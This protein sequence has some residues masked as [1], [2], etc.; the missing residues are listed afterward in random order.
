MAAGTRDAMIR[1]AA[2]LLRQEGIRGT[3]FGQVIEHSGAPRGS[4]NHH[5]PGGKAEMMDAALDSAAHEV[6]D[7]L[8]GLADLGLSSHDVVAGICDYFASGLQ[9][10]DFRAG[11]P[12]AAIAH[13]AH[14]HPELKQRAQRIMQRWQEALAAILQAEGTEK[15][16]A[17]ERALMCIVAI[18]GAVLASRLQSSREPL[19][20]VARQLSGLLDRQPS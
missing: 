10:T 19:D 13:E 2:A 17:E 5:F 6:L 11:C 14:G 12:V 1:S 18:E 3:S 20:I 9:A 7:A 16:A 15:P 4:I 8:E